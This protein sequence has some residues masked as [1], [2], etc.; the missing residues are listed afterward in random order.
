MGL[1]HSSPLTPQRFRGLKSRLRF[2]S[3]GI[4]PISLWIYRPYI[5]KLLQL[6]HA[7]WQSL[8]AY[9]VME[10][11]INS[12]NSFVT[13]KAF[14]S[15]I[16]KLGIVLTMCSSSFFRPS[17]GRWQA[18]VGIFNMMSKL[19]NLKG[20]RWCGPHGGHCCL[21]KF[22][23][24]GSQFPSILFHSFLLILIQKFPNAFSLGRFC[25]DFK[26]WQ[27]VKG[28]L[29]LVTTMESMLA[30]H[31]N[32]TVPCWLHPEQESQRLLIRFSWP[33][34]RTACSPVPEPEAIKGQSSATRYREITMALFYR[35]EQDIRTLPFES[36][37]V[38]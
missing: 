37:W 15:F 23:H 1:C 19:K 8:S 16:S 9:E 33:Q 18:P 14:R 34:G 28:W 4:I 3:C 5:I 12:L 31:R 24:C 6:S 10:R 20:G 38:E 11:F 2:G 22:R 21:T 26:G 13:G 25:M 35:E 36:I 32:P 7:K 17:S 27:C 29:F 30:A